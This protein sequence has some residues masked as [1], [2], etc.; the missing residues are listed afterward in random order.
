MGWKYRRM[1]FLDQHIVF[2]FVQ[3][4]V[5]H[6]IDGSMKRAVVAVCVMDFWMHHDGW[7]WRLKDNWWICVWYDVMNRFTRLD[8]VDIID[9]HYCLL[10]QSIGGTVVCSVCKKDRIIVHIPI[11]G[12]NNNQSIRA[13]IGLSDSFC[14]NQN[15]NQNMNV[16]KSIYP[17]KVSRCWSTRRQPK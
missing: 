2:S 3:Y 4:A 6:R 13:A 15:L 11:V 12:S 5:F 7:C 14:G 8:F 1:R 9:V 10:L 17:T 16:V